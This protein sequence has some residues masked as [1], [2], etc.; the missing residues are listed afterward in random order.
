MIQQSTDMETWTDI[1][2][3]NYVDVPDNVD[4]VFYRQIIQIEAPTP[5][6]PNIVFIL[7]D[8][9]RFD[10]YGAFGGGHPF[11]ETPSLD[12][13]ATEGVNFTR[14][15][16]TTPLCA[17]SRSSLFTGR[18]PSR[19]GI[20][21]HN[22]SVRGANEMPN[23]PFLLKDMK[24]AGYHTAFFGKWFNGKNFFGRVGA[25]EWIGMGQAYKPADVPWSGPEYWEWLTENVYTNMSYH[26]KWGG[27]DHSRQGYSTDILRDYTLDFIRERESATD[28]KP[29]FVFLSFL[30]PHNPF[31]P[32]EVNRDRYA[33]Q[34]IPNYPNMET[35][36]HSNDYVKQCEMLLSV[37]EAVRQILGAIDDNTII[38][39]SSDNGY[40]HGEHNWAGK[41]IPWEESVGVPLFWY[42]PNY[43]APRQSDEVVALLDVYQSFLDLAGAQPE[44]DGFEY[45]TSLLPTVY[46]QQPHRDEMMVM[47]YNSVDPTKMNFA[48]IITRDYTYWEFRNGSKS[49][50]SYDDPYQLNNLINEP[51]FDNVEADMKLRLDTELGREGATV[52]GNNPMPPDWDDR[53][54]LLV[55]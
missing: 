11:M 25:D 33:D 20:R 32:A 10:Q 27:R 48:Q 4:K 22:G 14:T 30:N 6:R 7:T 35:M 55:P 21:N 15:Y 12:R 43:V 47:H 52:T 9:M 46:Q 17:P 53:S 38:V 19:H 40:C 1:G 2:V 23:G 28:G 37:D 41:N 45:S 44:N 31:K 36:A 29:Y 42:D 51:A 39:F 3:N 34:T 16:V 18:L 54:W 50:Y 26:K 5:E 49:L 24:D 13:L 8:D